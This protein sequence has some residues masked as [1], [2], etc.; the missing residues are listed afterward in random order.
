MFVL[1]ACVYT[2]IW[3]INFCF[4]LSTVN[5][6]T[7]K[8]NM[9]TSYLVTYEPQVHLIKVAPRDEPVCIQS[10]KLLRA[11]QEMMVNIAATKSNGA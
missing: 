4:A 6:L 9:H 1:C 7:D 2:K 8:N 11:E 10:A 3:Y 5:F